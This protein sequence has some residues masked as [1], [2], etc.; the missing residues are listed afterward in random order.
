MSRWE[1]HTCV[2][3]D[4][5]TTTNLQSKQKWTKGFER[6]NEDEGN[7]KITSKR[8]NVQRRPC[9]FVG[10]IFLYGLNEVHILATHAK[11]ENISHSLSKQHLWVV[12]SMKK[13]KLNPEW[14]NV[15]SSV[16]SGAVHHIL[17]QV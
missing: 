10:G 13:C 5:N 14:T 3:G 1:S 12:I 6:E 16:R 8:K 15:P 2:V 11:S 17:N 9:K 7:A 4:E